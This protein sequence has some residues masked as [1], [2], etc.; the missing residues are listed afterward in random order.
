MSQCSDV[1]IT[2]EPVQVNSFGKRAFALPSR[3]RYSTPWSEKELKVT[4]REKKH[5]STHLELINMLEAVL[6]FAKASQ[7]F[8][9]IA[10]V[11]RQLILLKRDIQLQLIKIL[12][13][14]SEILMW[15]AAN[16]IWL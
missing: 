14:Y 2:S 8:Y 11:N 6:H 1:A 3:E 4:V 10:I 15:L 12:K 16:V 7:K 9:V 5:S 13:I